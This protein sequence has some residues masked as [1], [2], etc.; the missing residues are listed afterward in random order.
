MHVD[1]AAVRV[2]SE[3]EPANLRWDEAGADVVVDS[4]GRFRTRSAAAAHL[5][6]GA[7]KV[8]LS[9]PGKGVDATIVLGVNDH[10]YDPA[11][12]DVISNASCTTNCVAPMLLV[13][14]RRFVVR[15]GQLTTVHTYTNDQ[16][17]LDGPHKDPRRARSAAVN[18]IPATTG[19]AKA[20]GE[21]LPELAGLLDGVSRSGCRSRTAH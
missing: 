11:R 6:A 1:D 15:R 18:M 19:A 21:V 12:H 7:R 3:Q 5:A 13:L 16:N 2:T 8:V 9:A 14:H 10:H 20:V 4:T 17:L